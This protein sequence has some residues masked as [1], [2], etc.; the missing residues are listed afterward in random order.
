MSIQEYRQKYP[1][2]NDLSDTELMQGIHRKHYSDMPYPEF[3]NR[4]AGKTPTGITSVPV[5]PRE[6]PS[7]TFDQRVGTWARE[8]VDKGNIEPIPP[9]LTDRVLQELPQAGGGGVGGFAGGVMGAKAAARIPAGHP[10]LKGGMVLGGATLG[11]IGGGMG[12]KG[13]QQYYRQKKTGEVQS[14]K[15]MYTEQLIAGLEEG[16]GELVGRGVAKGAQKLLKPVAK[17]TIKRIAAPGA[18]E[19]SKVLL[20]HGSRPTLAQ[21]TRNRII[22]IAESIAEGAF[23]GGRLQKLKT[24]GQ[25]KAI[26]AAVDQMRDVFARKLTN[27][28]TP[29]QAGNILIDTLD[30]KA[31]VWKATK[32]AMYG[33]VDKLIKRVG[34]NADLIDI[35]SLK[36]FAKHNMADLVTVGKTEAGQNMYTIIGNLPDKISF[37]QAG[38][39]KHSLFLQSQSMAKTKDI[40]VG[41]AKQLNKML[42]GEMQMGMK[43][44]SGE[45][46]D[47]WLKANQIT[48]EGHEFFDK[49][50]IKAVMKN[51]RQNPE[52]IVSRV[53]QPEAVTQ[54]KLLKESVDP[55][56]WRAITDGYVEQA[57][58]KSTKKD[59][60]Q[61]QL[62]LDQLDELGE[63]LGAAFTESQTKLMK[64][65]GTAAE[66]TQRPTSEFSS[67]GRFIIALA[68]GGLVSGSA[69]V[70][71]PKTAMALVMVPSV[72]ARAIS[73]PVHAKVLLG[74]MKAPVLTTTT[75]ARLS[76]MMNNINEDIKRE[77]KEARIETR[78]PKSELGVFRGTRF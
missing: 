38:S 60:F 63:G 34:G 37:R 2:Y 23:T 67:V 40:S 53:F 42:H 55:G 58:K 49:K 44:L 19:V 6:I 13:W 4:M 26:K 22:D 66:V 7:E 8:E 69:W 24:L 61:G 35:K 16:A 11:A 31:T 47:M 5:D 46:L 10:L 51:L 56:T 41:A 50:I 27:T 33:Q 20:K 68:Q 77:Q 32:R 72:M 73:S 1:Q 57:I 78:S 54:I 17:G 75:M 59:V 45:A 21:L 12:G 39:L 71:R 9:T 14:L 70:N 18:E 74:A 28:L 48:K 30:G 76:N 52:K 25:P 29:T 3:V 15:D 36:S 65:I 43:S 64:M 62:F